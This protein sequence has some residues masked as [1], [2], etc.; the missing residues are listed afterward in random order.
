M[1][2]VPTEIGFTVMV[3]AVAALVVGIALATDFFAIGNVL[4]AKVGVL[5]AWIGGTVALL[6]MITTIV[7]L[8][9]GNGGGG[10]AF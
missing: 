5:L 3:G 6:W 4:A 1:F 8:M 2:R 9:R 7:S 10:D